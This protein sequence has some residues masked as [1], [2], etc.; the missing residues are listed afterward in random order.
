MLRK[1]KSKNFD[2]RMSFSFETS[3]VHVRRTHFP[4]PSCFLSHRIALYPLVPKHC[5][6]INLLFHLLPSKLPEQ[7]SRSP[8]T[9]LHAQNITSQHAKT[10]SGLYSSLLPTA[11]LKHPPCPKNSFKI[12]KDLPCLPCLLVNPSFPAEFA[13][14]GFPMAPPQQSHYCHSLPDIL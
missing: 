8:S 1:Y 9:I 2:S 14:L 4:R 7:F 12:S 3:P 10:L 5:I 11:E 13:K 6:T